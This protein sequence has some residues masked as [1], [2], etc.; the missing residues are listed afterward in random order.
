M[1]PQQFTQQQFGQQQQQFGQQ[2]QQFGQQ[3]YGPNSSKAPQKPLVDLQIYQPQKPAQPRP[4]MNP[5]MYMPTAMQT[6]TPYMPPQFNPYWPNFNPMYAPQLINPVVKQYSINNA[7]F[8]EQTTLR[9]GGIREDMLPSQ[10]N[11]TPNTLGERL[12]INNFVRS[13]FI[14]NHDGEDVDIDGKG[15]NSILRFLKLLE[16]NPYCSNN[17]QNNP[18]K[19]LPDNMLIYKS[20]YPIKYDSNTNSLQCG[21]NS[22]G[23]NVRIYSLTFAEYNVKK[24]NE[25]NYYNFDVWREVS[26]YEYIRENILKKKICPN[27]TLMY[28]YYICENCNIDR[29][30]IMLLKG[31]MTNVYK[32]YLM[33]LEKQ[34]NM[35]IKQIGDMIQY[36]NA[37]TPPFIVLA[38]IQRFEKEVYQ[39]QVRYTQ[40]NNVELSTH[41][42]QDLQ[43]VQTL[44]NDI[45]DKMKL[46]L[47]AFK[48]N[49]P[50]L[51]APKVSGDTSCDVT[52]PQPLTVK[53]QKFL[54]MLSPGLYDFSGKALITM[55][56]APTYNIFDWAS[57]KYESYGNINKMVSTG[58]HPYEVWRSV[59]FQVMV[60]LSVLQTHGFAFTKF[61][62]ADNV[63]IKD[64]SKHD[65]LKT[66][67]KYVIDSYE[68]YVPNHGYLVMIDSNYKDID[69]DPILLG[70]AKTKEFKIMSNKFKAGAYANQVIEDACFEAFKDVVD[71]NNYSKTFIKSGGISLPDDLKLLMGNI[72]SE[73][74]TGSKDIKNYIIKFMTGLLNNRVG[75]LLTELEQKHV[76]PS[77]QSGFKRGEIIVHE[78]DANSKEFV[79]YID[80]ISLGKAKIY[81]RNNNKGDIIDTVV[82]ST[83]LFHYSRH[84][85]ITQ[86]FKQGDAVMSEDNLLEVYVV[87]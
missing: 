5:L 36:V 52:G 58:F 43:K 10:F 29:N 4:Q 78:V 55:T 57:I 69:E 54:D 32:P 17:L 14:K 42:K 27:F 12:D 64:V 67:W 73:A 75:T 8:L 11:S 16:L 1:P 38:D 23:M 61:S 51:T 2:Q 40:L 79:I 86:D 60:A 59:L 68:Y 15:N 28:A 22:L 3:Q 80:M 74:Q 19:S 31:K 25:E 56:E 45:N 24:I 30:K 46:L 35:M 71:V 50:A 13:V 20:C 34:S 83:T 6:G 84:E 41:D 44:F 62:I 39:L 63:Y 65:N 7:P 18:Y 53:Q 82:S 26:Y 49:K 81:T 47:D 72:K 76:I 77:D 48:S 21:T 9:T 70:Q 87:G 37:R 33:F 85:K 66:Y